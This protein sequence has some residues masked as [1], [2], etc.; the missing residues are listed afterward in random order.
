VEIEEIGLYQMEKDAVEA[1]IYD[2][3]VLPAESMRDTCV[4]LYFTET[5]PIEYSDYA[6][7]FSEE[8]AAKLPESTP[9]VPFGPIYPHSANELST[10]RAYVDD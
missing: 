8:C 2:A 1:H 6:D 9:E 10:L 3:T 4:A 7:V 5:W